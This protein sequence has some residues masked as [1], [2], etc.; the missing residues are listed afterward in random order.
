MK[1]FTIDSAETS[2]IDDGIS[3]EK[4]AGI[5][6]VE[7]K[8]IWIHIADAERWAPRDS[9]LFD[10]ARRRVT[11]LYLPN[12]AIPMLPPKA[13]DDIMSLTMNKDSFALSLGVELKEDGSIDE[14]SIVVTPSLIRVSYRLT[15]DEVDEMLEEGSGYSEEWELGALLSYANKRRQYRCSR[16]S[17][18]GFVPTPIPQKQIKIKLDNIAPDGI[19]IDISVQAT[20]NSGTNQTS[21]AEIGDAFQKFT[22]EVVEPVSSAFTLVTETMILAGEAIGKWKLLEDEANKG[23]EGSFQNEV[24]LPFRTQRKPDYTSRAREKNIMMSL[25]EYNI[26]GGYCHAW[27]CRRFLSPVKVQE[28]CAPHS[29][30]GLSCYVQWTSPIRRYSDLLTHVSVK[31]YLRRQRVQALL[32]KGHGLKELDVTAEDIGCPL[33]QRI[34]SDTHDHDWDLSDMDADIDFREGGG[35]MGAARLLQRNSEQYYLF[36]YIRRI[37]EH[38]PDKTWDA[39]V[40]GFSGS[41]DNSEKQYAIYIYELGLEYRMTSPVNL[42]QGTEL[43]LKTSIISPRAG[44]LAFVRTL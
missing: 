1:V 37:H 33:P 23:I 14:S 12:G 4:Y 3:L 19:R 16:G 10:I 2:E 26:G 39:M 40:L 42:D 13:S 7:K 18:E 43:K 36:E 34:G 30:L 5:N 32:S 31:R 29:G 15:Y 24:S 41:G 11:S 20:H 27:Y 17:S 21:G 28:E 25:M 8:R 35:L 9:K 22:E 44:Q 38:D 6:G